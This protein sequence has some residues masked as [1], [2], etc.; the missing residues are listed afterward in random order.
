M[1]IFMTNTNDRYT[2]ELPEMETQ[3]I[4][5]YSIF[6]KLGE[7]SPV[8]S[9]EI[10]RKLLKEIERYVLF[11][12]SSEEHLMRLYQFP[13]F[14]V[15]QTDHERV[16]SKLLQYLDDFENNRL[17]PKAMR[18]F[19]VGWLMEH[20]CISDSEYVRWIASQRAHLLE[21]SNN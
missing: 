3:H 9:V 7:I 5:L 13:G 18:I 8:T 11:H 19:F 2:L 15:H 12:F 17:N 10:I 14:A 4:Y 20:S 16:E 21:N 6:D 1:E